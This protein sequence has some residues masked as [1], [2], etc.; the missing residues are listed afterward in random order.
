MKDYLNND[1]K[2]DDILA[3]GYRS[4]NSGAIKILQ[5]IEVH[6]DHIVALATEAYARKAKYYKTRH[7][8]IVIDH[9]YEQG[10]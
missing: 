4:G 10:K 1:I 8:A 2:V 3:Y 5:V 9:V 7:Q 6:A